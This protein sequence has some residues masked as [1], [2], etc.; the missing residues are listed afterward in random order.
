MAYGYH[1]FGGSVFCFFGR[2]PDRWFPIRCSCRIQ[3]N[4]TEHTLALFRLYACS[5]RPDRSCFMPITNILSWLGHCGTTHFPC[6]DVEKCSW[7]DQAR[8]LASWP[9]LRNCCNWTWP[10]CRDDRGVFIFIVA[11]YPT[12][13]PED[14]LKNGRMPNHSLEQ[15]RDSAGFA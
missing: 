3:L 6:T 8:L 10:L 11:G 15:T 5:S 13:R 1:R 4:H 7:N 9:A 12:Y 14:V 2:S